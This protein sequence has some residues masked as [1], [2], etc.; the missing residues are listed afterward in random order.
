VANER[1]WN[2]GLG[3]TPQASDNVIYEFFPSYETRRGPWTVGAQFGLAAEGRYSMN[4]TMVRPYAAYQLNDKCRAQASLRYGHKYLELNGND[5]DF[6]SSRLEMGASCFVGAMTIAGINVRDQRGR[7]INDDGGVLDVYGQ[8]WPI[9]ATSKDAKEL[10]FSPFIHHRFKNEV[11]VT[12]T[13]ERAGVTD[14]ARNDYFQSQDR[15]T[16]LMAFVEYPVRRDLTIYSEFSYKRGNR[17]VVGSN[18]PASQYGFERDYT[19]KSKGLFVG[20]N[21][22]F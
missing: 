3:G 1:G 21:H 6:V 8:P 19:Y 16:K 11:G 17:T 7:S 5:P 10:R 2:G 12:F 15:W 4:E 22:I 18:L 13:L 20:I 14:K 9:N